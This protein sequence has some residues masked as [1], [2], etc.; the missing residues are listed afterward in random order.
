MAVEL[1]HY[2]KNCL[3]IVLASANRIFPKVKVSKKLFISKCIR[4]GKVSVFSHAF[5]TIEFTCSL[6]VTRELESYN[7]D[8]TQQSHIDTEELTFVIPP[9]IESNEQASIAFSRLMKK[10]VCTY[11]TLLKLNGEFDYRYILPG[12]VKTTVLITADF[13]RWLRILKLERY[14]NTSEELKELCSELYIVLNELCSV[15]FNR[16]NLKCRI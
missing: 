6:A 14:S 13:L 4:F 11:K 10:V 12:A 5:A 9:I 1:L 3:D 2:N 15:I 16:T 8:I 7:F